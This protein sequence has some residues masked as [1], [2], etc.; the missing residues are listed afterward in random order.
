MHSMKEKYPEGF[1]PEETWYKAFI[2][3]AILFRTVQAIVK[4]RKFPAYQANI[5]TYTVACISWKSGGNIDFDF[6]W[7]HQALS[8][9]MQAMINNWVAKIDQK[10]RS[11]AGSRMTSEWAKKVRCWEAVRDVALDLPE[12]RPPELC[13]RTAEGAAAA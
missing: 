4:A 1:S 13:A 11:T 7:S 2:G 8:P 3:K 10:L 6:I 9:Q 12:P 5:T